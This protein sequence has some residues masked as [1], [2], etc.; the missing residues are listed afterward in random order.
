MQNR[1]NA[2]CLIPKGA[3]SSRKAA[4]SRSSFSQVLAPGREHEVAEYFAFL[5]ADSSDVLTVADIVRMTGLLKT[6]VIKHL[7]TGHIRSISSSPRYLVPKVY[8]LDFVASQH[9]IELRTDSQE[10]KRILV[11][12]EEWRR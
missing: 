12:F 11:G 9:F 7:C 4:S 1:E 10:F 3:V 8:L 5:Y 6:T 2:E